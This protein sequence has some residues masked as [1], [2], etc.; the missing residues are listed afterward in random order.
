VKR[1]HCAPTREQIAKLVALAADRE[2]NPGL[3]R[4]AQVILLSSEGVSGMAIA[5][6]LKLSNG[7]V[8]RIRARFLTEGVAG[9]SERPRRGRTDHAVSNHVVEL[10]LALAAS[11]PPP[12]HSRWSTRLIGAR[13]GLTSATVSK[14]LRSRERGSADAQAGA[15]RRSSERLTNPRITQDI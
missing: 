9:L 7:Q 14:I 10:V 1:A 11:T 5:S 6:R 4:R 3:A 13:V 8:S 2:A 12:G 15:A